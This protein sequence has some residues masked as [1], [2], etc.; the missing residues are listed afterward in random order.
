MTSRVRLLF[1]T[2]LAALFTGCA[3]YI[4]PGAKADL[5]ALAPADIQEG[6]AAKATAP[7][8]ASIAAVRLQAGGYANYHLQRSG[9]VVGE[10][11]YAAI[12]TREVEDD[13]QFD[14]VSHL[15][16]VAGLV[17]L[18]RLLL[19]TRIDSDR[20]IRLA[21]SRLQAD[22]VLVYTFDTAFFDV[23]KAKPLSVITLG[24][25]P[26]R[27]IT[28]TTTASALLIDTRTGY[29]YSAYE[30]SSQA[31][32]LATSWGTRDAAD[33]QRRNSERS[34]FGKL[35]DEMANSWPRLLERYAKKT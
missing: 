8:P 3:S 16:Q 32:T 31:E 28:A 34:A 30:A 29:I 26:T 2:L 25:S 18:N 4:A 7:F 5:Q 23:D 33:E 15:P 17:G 20:D 6:F 21:A 24:L 35:V 14:R 22:L 19:P 1:I 11:R 9:G 10:G 12:L 27:K 13:A